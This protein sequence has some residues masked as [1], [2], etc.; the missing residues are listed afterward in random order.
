MI[1]QQTPSN[2]NYFCWNTFGVILLISYII[3]CFSVTRKGGF[4]EI[5]RWKASIWFAL[6][7]DVLLWLYLLLFFEPVKSNIP[8]NYYE[9]IVAIPNF[10]ILTLAIHMSFLFI[11]TIGTH[12]ELKRWLN[13]DDYLDKIWKDPNKARKSPIQ[14][15]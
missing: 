8:S 2:T 5:R 14:E 10:L 1:E 9:L 11:A 12:F 3:F 6:I 13:S 15:L 4:Y 7:T